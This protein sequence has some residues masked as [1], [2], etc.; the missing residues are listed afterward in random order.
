MLAGWAAPCFALGLLSFL[1]A[2]PAFGS[3][4]GFG[5][6]PHRW[7]EGWVVRLAGSVLAEG[8]QPA[9]PQVGGC[10]DERNPRQS[11]WRPG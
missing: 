8:P 2:A 3:S 11:A 1:P 10:G 5:G 7:G 6:F 4:A 9:H